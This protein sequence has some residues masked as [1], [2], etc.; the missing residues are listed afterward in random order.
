MLYTCKF[1]SFRS[2]N[3]IDFVKHYFEAHSFEATFHYICG[4][5]SCTRVFT[6]GSSFDAFRSHCNQK[7]NNWQHD[8]T[9]TL[10]YPTVSSADSECT[11]IREASERVNTA[12]TSP[13]CEN[14]QEGT[15]TIDCNFSNDGVMAH[16]P[17][18]STSNMSFHKD[19]I[20]IAAAKFILTLKEKFKLTQTSLDYTVKGVEELLLLSNKFLEQSVLES[21]E[22]ASSPF[23]FH[24]SPFNDLKTEYQQTKF[25]KENFGL[26]VSAYIYH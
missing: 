3:G 24:S 17:E 6:S 23:C 11:S 19:T 12:D 13:D 4:I 21:P 20:K 9:P 10:D 7:H 18:Q 5:S 8:F 15:N 1:C 22:F 26:V 16:D 2:H 14:T 25:F